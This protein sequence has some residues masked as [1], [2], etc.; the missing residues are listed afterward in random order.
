MADN[1]FLTLRSLLMADRSVRRF[2]QE[3]RVSHDTLCHLVDL[4]RFCASGRN[5]QPLRYRLVS[6]AEECDAIFP[7]MAWAGYLTDWDGPAPEERPTAY[8]VQCLDTTYGPNLL[9]DDGLHLQAI[10][11]GATALG[12]GGCIIK[13]FNVAKLSQ[14]LDIPS[15]L[16]PLYVLALGAPAEEVAIE[17]TDGSADA[18]IKYYRSDDEVHHVPKRPLSQLIIK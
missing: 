9:C 1:T 17:P 5:M 3:P 7:L 8:L 16:T 6:D 10:T 14:A 15:H 12:I 4:T 2:H 18:D 13:S 11:L